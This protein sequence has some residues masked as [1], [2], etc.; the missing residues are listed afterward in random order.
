M[1]VFVQSDTR[2]ESK[3][4]QRCREESEGDYKKC[5]NA[6][7]MLNIKVG[8]Y[9]SDDNQQG[10]YDSADRGIENGSIQECSAP[11]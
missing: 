10:R 3:S 7:F 2:F 5:G 1:I 8:A 11:P 9:K 6:V 4:H